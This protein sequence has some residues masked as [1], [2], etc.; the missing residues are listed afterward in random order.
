[1]TRIMAIANQKGGVGKTTTVL[2]LGTALTEQGYK[3]LL[4]DSDP[5]GS[6]TLSCGFDP[7]KI[8]R[9]LY[10]VL[11]ATLR[12]NDEGKESFLTALQKRAQVRKDN[13]EGNAYVAILQKHL[14]PLRPRIM[15]I[16]L[17]TEAG[18]DLVPTNIELSQADIDLPREPL[19]VYALRDSL[20][21]LRGRYDFVLIDTP[22]NLGILT[23]NALAV[24]DSVLVPLQADYLAMKGVELL[25]Q[26]V[27]KVQRRINENLRIEGVVLTMADTR[28]IHAK[29]MIAA[30]TQRLSKAGIRVFDSVIKMSVRVKEAPVVGQ[31]VLT[32]AGDSAGAQAYRDLARELLS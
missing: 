18:P 17:A 26:T 22:P 7:E 20:E 21:P 24:A 32:Y 1:M 23:L 6:L 5:Q 10:T 2:T 11:S 8:E 30:S 13:T 15:D 25:L 16:I 31:S 14:Q 4:V 12:G 9:T 29:E 27:A 3:V 19:G 28:T